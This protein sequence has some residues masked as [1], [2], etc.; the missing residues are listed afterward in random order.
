MCQGVRRLQG[1]DDALGAAQQ[2]ES[3]DGLVVGGGDVLDATRIPQE[4]V[5]RT[6]PRVI[7]PGGDGVHLRRVAVLVLQQQRAHAVQRPRGAEGDRRGVLTGHTEVAA[8]WFDTE[9]LHRLVL[10]ESGEQPQGI[11][12]A[13]NSC[14]QSI[15]Q[16]SLLLQHLTA[17]LA[18]D[19]RLEVPHHRW[20]RVRAD[21]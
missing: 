20:V 13:A 5:L 14:H 3:G 19:D 1:G 18:T 7:Q 2:L 10:Q 6:D 17:S 15:R 21:G 11:R 16:T 8:R 9:H 12:S 4:G